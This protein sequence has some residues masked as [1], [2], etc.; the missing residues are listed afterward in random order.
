MGL[1][2]SKVSGSYNPGDLVLISDHYSVPEKIKYDGMICIVISS[3]RTFD[4]ILAIDRD[5]CDEY[6]HVKFY[7]VMYDNEIHFI[8]EF[9]IMGKIL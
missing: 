5:E 1:L 7:E 8:S 3:H 4:D 2:L 6:N 9:D